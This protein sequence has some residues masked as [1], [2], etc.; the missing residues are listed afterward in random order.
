MDL[1]NSCKTNSL[2]LKIGLLPQK[3][4]LVFQPSIFSCKIAVR[5]KEGIWVDYHKFTNAGHPFLEHWS[6]SRMHRFHMFDTFGTGGLPGRACCFPRCKSK[7]KLFKNC[8]D[9]HISYTYYIYIYFIYIYIFTLQN[10]YI[11]IYH[12]SGQFMIYTLI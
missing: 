5:F 2:P 6:V 1:D 11:Y 8:L 10:K 7:Q 3:E 4:R 9:K 12:G